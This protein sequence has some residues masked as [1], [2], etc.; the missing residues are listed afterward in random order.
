MSASSTTSVSTISR[1]V[2]LPR[3]ILGVAFPHRGRR[4][5][6]LAAVGR[7]RDAT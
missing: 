1:R 4:V 6:T 5:M 2:R 3:G 7:S